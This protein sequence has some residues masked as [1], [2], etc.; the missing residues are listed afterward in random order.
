MGNK[1][2]ISLLALLWFSAILLFLGNALSTMQSYL[3]TYD[4]LRFLKS[5]SLLESQAV[6]MTRRLWSDFEEEDYCDFIEE[7]EV[8]WD[9]NDLSAK[10]TIET[11]DW[12]ETLEI[13][14]DNDCD[15][16]TSVRRKVD[17]YP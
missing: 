11:D 12:S 4:N 17:K 2:F 7:S 8:C 3:V 13:D 14:Y 9:F 1:G 16:L 15:C 6:G 10:V 5:R